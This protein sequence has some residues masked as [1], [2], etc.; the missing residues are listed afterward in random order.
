MLENLTNQ[1]EFYT[2][3][4]FTQKAGQLVHIQLR[5]A[6]KTEIN[7]AWDDRHFKRFEENSD[8]KFNQSTVKTN[9]PDRIAKLDLGATPPS[10]VILKDKCQISK[11]EREKNSKTR[12]FER[13]QG[14]IW[15]S[16]LDTMY[17]CEKVVLAL[18]AAAQFNLEKVG[19]R[20]GCCR[21][22]YQ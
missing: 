13:G 18:E 8:N 14:E 5:E 9:N 4:K 19:G 7:K 12:E 1:D 16:W 17:A 2:D 11:I 10:N 20:F 22:I 15:F 21:N 6:V 3:F